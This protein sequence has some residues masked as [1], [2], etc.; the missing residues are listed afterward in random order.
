MA[1]LILIHLTALK[2]HR[3]CPHGLCE[4]GYMYTRS[5]RTL[6]AIHVHV[7]FMSFHVNLA[8]HVN[9]GGIL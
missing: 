4:R 6:F 3:T 1:I 5:L 2:K 7:D 8:K 9:F